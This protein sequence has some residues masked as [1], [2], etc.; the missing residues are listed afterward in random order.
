ML[1]NKDVPC[2]SAEEHEQLLYLVKAGMVFEVQEWIAD[3][4]PSLR[5][6]N[7][8]KSAL[9]IAIAA[10]NHSMVRVLWE[11]AWQDLGEHECAVSDALANSKEPRREIARYL[12]QNK[13]AIGRW[14]N[15]YDLCLSHDEDLIN[16]GVSRG[17]PIIGEDGFADALVYT[18]SKWLIGYYRRSVDSN[19]GLKVEAAKALFR[20]IAKSKIRLIALLRWA[21]VDPF[22]E[23]SE[24]VCSNELDGCCYGHV[25]PVSSLFHSQKLVDVLDVLKLKPTTEQWFELIER[26]STSDPTEIKAL[27][28]LMPHH[29]KVLIKYPDEA[30]EVLRAVIRRCS[31][32]F[33]G[34][35]KNRE[36]LDYGCY[37]I[38]LGVQALHLSHSEIKD[39]R[40]MLYDVNDPDALVHMLWY[41][42]EMG[43]ERTRESMHELVRTGKM[44]N[45]V[46]QYYPW[47]VY[48]LGFLDTPGKRVVLDGE[49]RWELDKFELPEPWK[50]FAENPELSRKAK[51]RG[52]NK[53]FEGD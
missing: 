18:G 37:L 44:Q 12:L 46:K 3:G 52:R 35:K 2:C 48:D 7:S 43:D 34:G 51:R 21:G 45:M 6:R 22:F 39:F 31:Y 27:L 41:I 53:A 8:S 28:N 49:K 36:W 13:C 50:D 11:G 29:Q 16:L 14:A 24:E 47:L 19:P 30:G 15:G 9:L 25:T 20:A 1:A 4:K 17:V 32:G 23:F 33:Y 38:S 40:R 42:Y 10:G 26:A 5:P